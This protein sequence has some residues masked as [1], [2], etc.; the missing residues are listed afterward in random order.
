MT[1]YFSK[2]NVS[3][4]K[5]NIKYIIAHTVLRHSKN[6]QD[7]SQMTEVCETVVCSNLLNVQVR[8]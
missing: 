5:G 1:I 6:H 8:G 7:G 3:Q 2:I 4:F